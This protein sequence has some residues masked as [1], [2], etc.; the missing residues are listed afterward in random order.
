MVK[1][2][3]TQ[4]SVTYEIKLPG[5]WITIGPG[6]VPTSGASVAQT[7]IKDMVSK[8]RKASKEGLFKEKEDRR[9]ESLRSATE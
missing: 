7:S 2:T 1:T 4:K 5:E 3:K 8:L 6:T 9:Y